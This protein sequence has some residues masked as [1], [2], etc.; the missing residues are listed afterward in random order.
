MLA[1]VSVK[2]K[3]GRKATKTAETTLEPAKSNARRISKAVKK[4]SLEEEP[5]EKY[6]KCEPSVSDFVVT[7]YHWIFVGRSNTRSFYF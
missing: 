5:T 1:S 2:P 4:T 6:V 7:C 3:R